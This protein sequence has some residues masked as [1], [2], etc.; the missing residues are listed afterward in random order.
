MENIK[1]NVIIVIFVLVFIFYFYL[2]N[3]YFNYKN[4]RKTSEHFQSSMS[5]NQIYTL[6][7]NVFLNVASI[8]NNFKKIIES[9]LGIHNVIKSKKF[10]FFDIIKDP[11][12]KRELGNIISL[13]NK[14]NKLY[15]DAITNLDSKSDSNFLMKMSNLLSAMKQ[16]NNEYRLY[17]NPSFSFNEDNMAQNESLLE[18]KIKREEIIIKQH[19]NINVLL[20]NIIKD[21][22][23]FS[24][25]QN[26][27]N[28]SK[29]YLEFERDKNKLLKD[30]FEANGIFK[31][32]KNFLDFYKKK[33]KLTKTQGIEYNTINMKKK[34]IM[35]SILMLISNQ[36]KFINEE[37]DFKLQEEEQKNKEIEYLY[38]ANNNNN[39]LANFCKNL[40]KLDKPNEGN[41]ITK[42]LHKEFKNK[43]NI[44][45][46]KLE[47][48]IKKLINSMT[49]NQVNKYNSYVLRTH[50]M[51]SKQYNAIKKAKENLDNAK[52]IKINV[53]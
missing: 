12:F 8:N 39:T 43:K 13:C 53:S 50:D 17:H 30:L 28:F 1:Y 48:E 21:L 6:F 51:A 49:E 46:K 34:E 4:V 10:I 47:D 35:S 33:S 2:E 23:K 27:F 44:Q 38:S 5:N 7:K 31:T 42:R 25:S 15:N 11:K 52:K 19:Q 36:N 22:G 41:L 24:L 3:N 26:I 29:K 14:N 45:I 18:K 20:N 40:N 9:N 32:L 16:L 37:I